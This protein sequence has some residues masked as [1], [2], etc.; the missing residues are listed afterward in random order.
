MWTGYNWTRVGPWTSVHLF[1]SFFQN[2]K[3]GRGGTLAFGRFKPRIEPKRYVNRLCAG[4][5]KFSGDG[6][7]G[8]NTDLCVVV[9]QPLLEVGAIQ[10]EARPAR[11][12]LGQQNLAIL[13]GTLNSGPATRPG[14]RPR[15]GRVAFAKAVAC[16][17]VKTSPD[18]LSR[19]V[20]GDA[21]PQRRSQRS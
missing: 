6:R 7:K 11:A 19:F 15:A 21:V 14:R 9:A 4:S 12:R 3:V 2:C 1:R 13:G 10:P 16:V 20:R 8:L 5:A 18:R 17:S